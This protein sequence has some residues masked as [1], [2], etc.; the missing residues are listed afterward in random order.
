MASRASRSAPRRGQPPPRVGPRAS[1]RRRGDRSIRRW[2]IKASTNSCSRANSS[3][4]DRQTPA[5][6]TDRVRHR[7]RRARSDAR[8]DRRRFVR[9]R[10]GKSARTS[11]SAH[12]YPGAPRSS[13]A[14][15]CWKSLRR[16][17]RRR[18]TR[19]KSASTRKYDMNVLSTHGITMRGVAHDTM[20]ESY[21]WNSTATRH[22]M[23]Y[24]GQE[25]PRLQDHSLRRRDRQRRQ[26]D[27]VLAGRCRTRD[28]NTPPKM[29]TS[30]CVCTKRCGRNSRPKTRLRSCLREHRNAAGAG[31]RAHGADRRADRCR[32]IAPAERRTGQAHACELQ[33]QAYAIAGRHFS[34][35][36]PKQLQQILFEELK[37]PVAFKTPSGQPSTNEEALEASPANQH[38]LP[39]LILEYRGL[40]KLRSTYT[41]KLA[42]HDQPAHRAR[43]HELSPGRRADRAACRPTIR[44]CRT[45]RSAPKKA[46]AS[47]RRS[48]RRR[49]ARSWP[50]TIRRSSC[51]SWRTCLAMPA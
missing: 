2:P 6:R 12:D 11:R 23:D 40:A 20:L 9:G 21:V 44:I 22:D 43:A 47:A 14:M 30:R 19:R 4:V 41:D 38:E 18:R 49:A 50:P 35:D 7:N 1:R 24:A 28:A 33:Q 25:I 3:S 17:A 46:G 10:T 39:R 31:A 48:S 42:G 26:A 45:S 51:A 34:L 13:I 36:S 15:S 29:P 27:S 16:H 5:G 32:R 37:L 8:G